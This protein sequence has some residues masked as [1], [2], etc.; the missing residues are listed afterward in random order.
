MERERLAPLRGRATD[1]ID[2]THLSVH[3]LRRRVVEGFGG[4]GRGELRMRARCVSFG[5]KYGPRGRRCRPRRP[6]PAEPVLRRGA[7]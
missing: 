1:L 7:A 6:L 5:F 3:E 2:T 4:R